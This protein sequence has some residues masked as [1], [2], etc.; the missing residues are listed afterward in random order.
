MVFHTVIRFYV[1]L[2]TI[3][4][5]ISY[6]ECTLTTKISEIRLYPC[7]DFNDDDLVLKVC[8][9]DHCRSSLLLTR[10]IKQ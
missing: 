9:Y 5:S 4:I 8:G 1:L 10:I 3:E 6:P 2:R 7:A